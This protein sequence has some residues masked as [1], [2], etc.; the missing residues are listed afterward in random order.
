MLY[1]YKNCHPKAKVMDDSG[2]Q[3]FCV[4]SIDTDKN[5]LNTHSLTMNI[6]DEADVDPDSPDEYKVYQ[7]PFTLLDIKYDD[8]QPKLFVVS[9]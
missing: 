7:V 3:L 6:H 5:V 9:L 8:H 4:V 1:N 2:K